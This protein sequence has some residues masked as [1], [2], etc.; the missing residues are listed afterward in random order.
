VTKFLSRVLGAA[1]LL[2]WA[3]TA[4]ATPF[5]VTFALQP[6]SGAIQ[7]N[8]G[9][10]IGWGYE[11]VNEDTTN[12]FV[13]TSLSASSF[14][15][16]TP[17]DTYFDFPILAPGDAGTEAFDAGGRGGLYAVTINPLAVAGQTEA[18]VFTLSGEWWLGDPLGTGMFLQDAT[19]IT[20]NFSFAVI[21]EAAVPEPSSLLLLVAGVA[22]FVYI[23]RFRQGALQKFD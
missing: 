1:L 21:G 7:G 8:P 9:D 4:N 12:W 23:L 20:K 22:L 14:S 3:G 11:L 16:G 19:P 18:G 13:P 5:T 15:L 17:D 2:C 10:L 6:A